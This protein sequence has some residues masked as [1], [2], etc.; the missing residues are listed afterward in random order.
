M[1]DRNITNARFIQVNQLPQIDSHLTAKRYVDNA[2]SD[3]IDESSLLRLHPYT[4]SKLEERG[5]IPL[6]SSITTPRTILEIPIKENV[7][8]KFNDRSIIKNSD[9]VDFNDKDIDNVGW[10][11]VNKMP[12]FAEHLT[13][14]IYV[15]NAMQDI[16]SAI[17]NLHE[18]NRNR[19]DLSLVF[20]DQDNVFDKNKLNNLDSVT[21]NRNPTSDNELS[22]KKYVY[23][24][25]GEGTIVRFNQTLENY[26]KVSVGNDTYNLTK[27][28]K[29]QIRDTTIS[30]YPNTGGYL[31]QNWVI[32]CND[33]NNNGKNQNFINSTKTNSPT[34]FSGAT[35]LS[36]I[37]NSFMYI[38]TSS[39]NHGN[40]AFVSFEQADIIQSSNITFFYTRFSIL[41]NY[42]LKSMGRF[43]IQLL[44]ADNTWSI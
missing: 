41:T 39:N 32:T 33:K 25:I 19:K 26:L 12:A 27:Y 20:N 42:S 30:I 21:V 23:D 34:G 22:N 4:I 2:I 5:Y 14:K 35:S 24:S 11:K 28:D 40:N 10:I 1:N 15:D 9:H 13:P 8:R 37:G 38:E 29:I 3:S 7:D 36:P 18:L 44:L 16:K 17:I 6:D 43:R 31:L